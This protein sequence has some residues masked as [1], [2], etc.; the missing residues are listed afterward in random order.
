MGIKI[1][2][3][4]GSVIRLRADGS[5][6]AEAGAAITG[7]K[8]TDQQRDVIASKAKNVRVRAF[9]GTGKS[10]T[11][12]GYAEARPQEKMLYLAYNAAIAAKAREKFPSNVECR[13]GHSLAFGMAQPYSEQRGGKG[14]GDVKTVEVA[15]AMQIQPAG[16]RVVLQALNNFFYSAD[17]VINVG[18]VKDAV[19]PRKLPDMSEATIDNFLQSTKDLWAR[20]QNKDDRT[21]MM[22]HDGY[23]K[24]FHLSNPQLTKY[25]T[26][27]FDESQ[28]ANPVI[29]AIVKAQVHAG[30][31]YVGDK[32][33][34]I[35]E[36]RGADDALEHFEYDA[37]FVLSKSFRFG[38]GVARIASLLLSRLK[39]E[40][41]PVEG[42]GKYGETKFVVD[43]TKQ[44]A[45]ICRTNALLLD[46]AVAHLDNNVQLHFVGGPEKYRFGLIMD[47]FAL[48]NGEAFKVRDPSLKLFPNWQDF[49]LFATESNDPEYKILIKVIEKYTDRVPELVDRVK[50]SHQPNENNAEVILTTAH[51]SK[52]LEF[53]QVVLGEDFADLLDTE[54]PISDQEVNLLY[55]ASTRA[56]QAIEVPSNLQDWLKS[57][58][59]PLRK[60]ERDQCIALGG[61]PHQDEEQESCATAM[62]A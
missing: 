62:S 9:A 33:Q 53:P 15:R 6:N 39:E 27:L 23:L 25:K 35:Y 19:D 44:Y 32:H 2:A 8:Y 58:G 18:H 55:V 4:D 59:E 38:W 36:F 24:L 56:E 17:R 49:Q 60:I 14:L 31:V 1:A 21:F 5:T 12:V 22:P 34:S 54:N 37:D 11:L 29:T 20:I 16:A 45:Q 42:L 51:R 40:P 3:D 7:I 46:I 30:K 41:T 57:I 43:R 28:D 48:W 10:S 52:G 26:I 47:A 61:E 13:T 50:A